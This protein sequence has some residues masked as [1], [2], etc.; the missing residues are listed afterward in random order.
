MISLENFLTN[1][2]IAYLLLLIAIMFFVYL[3]LRFPN[4]EKSPKKKTLARS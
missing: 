1:T 4:E 2:N 3:V